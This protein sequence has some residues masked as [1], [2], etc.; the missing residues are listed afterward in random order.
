MQTGGYSTGDQGA[1]P[2][3][4]PP[5]PVPLAPPGAPGVPGVNTTQPYLVPMPA[6]PP[7]EWRSA[8][9]LPRQP[10]N[11][12]ASLVLGILSIFLFCIVIPG[13]LALILGLVAASTIKRSNGSLKGLGVARA[14]W[15]LGLVSLVGMAAF[16]AAA[17]AGAFDTGERSVYELAV[18]DCVDLS[19]SVDA[20]GSN[21]DTEVDELPIVDCSLPHDGEVYHLGEIERFDEYPGRRPVLANVELVCTGTVFT[22]YVG[23]DYVDSEFGLFTLSPTDESWP[24]GDRGFICIATGA[25]GAPLVGSVRGSN[26]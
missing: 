12:T 9:S 7:H 3:P 15:I 24:L 5:P 13:L 23:I 20:D 1:S 8:P 10:G 19:G 18:G 17:A 14:G 11:A 16:V 22:D 26:R 4:P 25:G 21:D 2:P 6:A